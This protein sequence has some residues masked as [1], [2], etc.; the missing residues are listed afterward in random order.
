MNDLV[1]EKTLTKEEFFEK[2]KEFLN[3]YTI[4][5]DDGKKFISGI[6]GNKNDIYRKLFW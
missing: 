6:L 5:L 3:K 1:C 2:N 4:P